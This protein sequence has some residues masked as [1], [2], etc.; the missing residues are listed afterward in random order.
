M[1]TAGLKRPPEHDDTQKFAEPTANGELRSSV[2][3]FDA[4]LSNLTGCL[5]RKILPGYRVLQAYRESDHSYRVK[6][7]CRVNHLTGLNHLAW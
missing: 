1:V 2:H 7:P 6:S 3:P 4:G 5:T